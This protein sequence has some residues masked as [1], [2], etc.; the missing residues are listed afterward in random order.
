LKKIS[1]HILEQEKDVN[2]NMPKTIVS[3]IINSNGI[4]LESNDNNK[5]QKNSLPKNKG[6]TTSLKLL[7][8]INLKKNPLPKNKGNTSLK[9]LQ[10]IVKKRSGG[11]ESRVRVSSMRA[12][13]L[14]F[15]SRILGFFLGKGV[16]RHKTLPGWAGW[17]FQRVSVGAHGGYRWRRCRHPGGVP[18]Y[19][20]ERTC[21]W[22][23][24]QLH[25]W[26]L[27][28]GRRSKTSCGRD[29]ASEGL[30]RRRWRIGWRR[31]R[32]PGGAP[33]YGREGPICGWCRFSCGCC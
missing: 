17:G 4:W 5:L 3:K 10:K 7:R 14:G 20:S 24:D 9:L 33:M 25:V 2:L 8:K 21:L 32:H 22:V 27:A 29:G 1:N 13:R 11:F 28:G 31:C 12:L 19:W 15:A 30:E 6:N 26:H 18:L 16:C 23:A